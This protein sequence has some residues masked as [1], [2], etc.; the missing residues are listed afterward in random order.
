MLLLAG[1][2]TAASIHEAGLLTGV[3]KA[4]RLA[5]L[6]AKQI[7]RQQPLGPDGPV[8]SITDEI[9]RA[10]GLEPYYRRPVSWAQIR[11]LQRR[12]HLQTGRHWP[13]ERVAAAV[14][15]THAHMRESRNMDSPALREKLQ[16]DLA[17][18]RRAF[19]GQI[20]EIAEARERG[21]LLTKDSRSQTYDLTEDRPRPRSLQLKFFQC[22][23]CGLRGLQGDLANADPRS[24]HGVLGR[25]EIAM[26][27]R[28]GQLKANRF[29]GGQQIYTTTV[30]PRITVLPSRAFDSVASS[31]HYAR[32][33]R[34]TVATI[35][36]VGPYSRMATEGIAVAGALVAPL[37][38]FEA[39]G[40]GHQ[41]M[42]LLSDS[43]DGAMVLAMFHLAI[44]LGHTAE[45]ATLLWMTG[46]E[47]AVLGLEGLTLFDLVAAEIFLPV[48]VVV[49]GLKFGLAFYEY[50][51]GRIGWDQFR[52]QA[53]GPALFV[54][55]ATT[56]GAVCSVVPVAGTI[57]CAVGGAIISVP[58]SLWD[59][60]Y[61][62]AK[63]EAFEK[64]I[65]EVRRKAIDTALAIEAR[66]FEF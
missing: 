28:S 5:E 3:E 46:S 51:S 10:Q 48:A 26:L 44:T 65:F 4:A 58:V 37:I 19:H 59:R 11:T 20:A 38:L 47:L 36:R 6:E 23:S 61:R 66:R 16:R 29:A 21:M 15:Y 41:A 43:G 2:V 14:D 55:F 22:P 33:G 57:T 53:T 62:A 63:R 8:M 56:G 34:A 64:E 45:A 24:R 9:R 31:Q 18:E 35:G 54:V 39:Y 7:R 49:Q 17:L 32:A 60:Y 12:L 50:S 30:G 13:L 27:E 42:D 52:D 1:P 25:Q 40:H